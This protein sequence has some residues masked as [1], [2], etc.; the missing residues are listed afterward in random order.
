MN[1]KKN[2]FTNSEDKWDFI[3][4]IIV[5]VLFSVFIYQFLFKTENKT[6][7]DTPIEL[8]EFQKKIP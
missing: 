4:A 2:V 7:I 3:I 8:N 6:A 5:I 1:S